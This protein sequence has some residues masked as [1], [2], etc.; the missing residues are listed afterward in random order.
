MTIIF[1]LSDS[2]LTTTEK[3]SSNGKS[4]YIFISDVVPQ[5]NFF[6]PNNCS[7]TLPYFTARFIFVSSLVTALN[8]HVQ[9]TASPNKS[10]I[11]SFHNNV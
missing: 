3:V 11:R 5:L 8:W 2:R 1:K 6:I 7:D 9:T 10:N 4:P